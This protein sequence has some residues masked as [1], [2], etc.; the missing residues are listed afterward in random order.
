MTEV[1][2]KNQMIGNSQKVGLVPHE[3]I[4]LKKSKAFI[5]ENGGVS[6]TDLPITS[7]TKCVSAAEIERRRQA[8]IEQKHQDQVARMRNIRDRNTT[9]PTM[10]DAMT[11]ARL[12]G[13][14]VDVKV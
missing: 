4:P 3:W 11:L 8:A 14:A 13:T 5:N 12:A 7:E 6:F 1:V 2:T 9:L 10:K